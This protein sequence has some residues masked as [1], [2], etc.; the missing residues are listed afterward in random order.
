MSRYWL[1]PILSRLPLKL[2]A[3][4]ICCEATDDLDAFRAKLHLLHPWLLPM[5]KTSLLLSDDN[6]VCG[7]TTTEI[8][9]SHGYELV[10]DGEPFQLSHC[11]EAFF[12]RLLGT[13]KAAALLSFDVEMSDWTPVQLNWLEHIS[14]WLHEGQEVILFREDGV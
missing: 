4:R 7:P 1:T 8:E 13:E 5:F 2:G 14:K 3:D 12:V 6:E 9:W 10:F 11:A